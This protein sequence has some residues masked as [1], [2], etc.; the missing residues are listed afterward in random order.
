MTL[1]LVVNYATMLYKM[2]IMTGW[3]RPS[4]G[5]EKVSRAQFATILWRMED[6]PEAV[7]D[8]N[9][10]PDVPDGEFFTKPV[11]WLS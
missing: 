3:K 8:A 11:M 2:D 4:V 6:M 7:Y 1:L 10:F 9:R 5:V